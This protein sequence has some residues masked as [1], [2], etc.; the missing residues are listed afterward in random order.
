M[1]QRIKI[2]SLDDYFLN[3]SQRSGNNVFF[4]S[5]NSYSKEIWDFLCRYYD[6]V[7]KNGVVIDGRIPNVD[8]NQLSY[9]YE[10]MG[11]D[12]NMNS[13][14]IMTSLQK[15]LPRMNVIQ[16]KEI[17]NAMY[18]VLSELVAKG[19]NINIV[20]NA[21]IKFMCWL[22]YRFESLV[23]RLGEESLPKILCNGIGSHYELMILSVLS[24]AGCDIVLVQ[25]S[26]NGGFEPDSTE[27]DI[28]IGNGT[29]FPEDFSIRK[30]QQAVD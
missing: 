1:F 12:F 18:D 19:K 21:Y 11:E 4:Y 9:Y 16:R 5:I 27:V 26:R 7:R 23:S 29:E 24:R 10:M 6:E 20:K 28:W 17:S 3:L 22:Y 14:F 13:Q 30:L 25:N 8:Q 2:S 15:W